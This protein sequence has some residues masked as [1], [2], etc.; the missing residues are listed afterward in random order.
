VVHFVHIGSRFN[1]KTYENDEIEE[2]TIEKGRQIN[3]WLIVLIFGFSLTLFSFY[4]S[5]KLYEYQMN[6]ENGNICIE[7]IIIPFLFLTIYYWQK[8]TP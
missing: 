3:N 6:G 5:I 2:L 4:Y 1:Y 8:I 7:E